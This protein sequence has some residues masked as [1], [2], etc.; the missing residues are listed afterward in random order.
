MIERE[1]DEDTSW[2]DDVDEDVEEWLRDQPP[3]EGDPLSPNGPV[4]LE[5]V[6]GPTPGENA[7]LDLLQDD[8][9][10][11]TRY[12]TVPM[13]VETKY[14]QAVRQLQMI[15]PSQRTFIRALVQEAGDVPSALRVY[16]AR[17]SKKLSYNQVQRWNHNENYRG[18]LQTALNYY[19]DL[20]GINPTNVLLKSQRVYSAAMEP[21][22]ILHKG[23][24]TGHFERQL[25]VA[26][27]MVETQGKWVGLEK[28]EN[29]GGRARVRIIRLSSRGQG[30]EAIDVE[31]GGG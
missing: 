1:D 30:D 3:A 26:A 8:T 31:V 21:A 5:P 9:T 13:D 14:V 16:N 15:R 27:R 6:A 20:H 12:P 19:L 10:P 2:L 11:S 24:A 7:F 22:P 23:R 17:F 18:A 29:N 28:P 25:G 4:K